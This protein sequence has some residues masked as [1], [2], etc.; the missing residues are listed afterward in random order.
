VEDLLPQFISA[1]TRYGLDY[2][3]IEFLALYIAA[4]LIACEQAIVVVTPHRFPELSVMSVLA[5][6]ALMILLSSA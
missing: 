1:A 4:H 5:S 6:G 3:C 2:G